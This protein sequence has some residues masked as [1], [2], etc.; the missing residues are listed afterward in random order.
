MTMIKRIR[1]KAE[2]K[3]LA[4]DLEV[5]KDWHEPDEQSLTTATFGKSFDNC[6][7]WG[8]E[9]LSKREFEARTRLYDSGHTNTVEDY[10]IEDA[11]R[12]VET[13][14]V[15]YK[16]GHAVAEINLATL[17]AFACDTYEG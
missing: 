8:L 16:G 15:L 1:R 14:V 11:E 7:H 10:Q 5:R 2:L 6:G 4:K 3:A 17:F 13:F 12:F 9:F